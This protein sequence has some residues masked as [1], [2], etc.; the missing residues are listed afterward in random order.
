MINFNVLFS[1]KIIQKKLEI[2]KKR[3]FLGQ[4]L[5]F[6][7]PRKPGLYISQVD[8]FFF[9]YR[10]YP[11]ECIKK[12]IS[13]SDFVSCKKYAVSANIC[14]DLIFQ[15]YFGL[16]WKRLFQQKEMGRIEVNFSICKWLLTLFKI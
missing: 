7:P 15:E 10:E 6:L 2:F 16:I 3:N 12:F 1:S 8:F 5:D 4:T 11:V 9:E 13:C 14:L